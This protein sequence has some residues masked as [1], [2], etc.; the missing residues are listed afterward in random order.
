LTL[1]NIQYTEK[2]MISCPCLRIISWFLL[3]GRD[4]Y[5]KEQKAFLLLHI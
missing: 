3:A 4:L 1:R 5:N 2:S